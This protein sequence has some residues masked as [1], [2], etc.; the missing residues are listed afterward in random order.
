MARLSVKG[1]MTMKQIY[2]KGIVCDGVEWIHEGQNRDQWTT[3]V[4]M[5]LKFL[6]PFLE[7]STNCYFS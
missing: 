4:N 7:Q 2:H 6:S 5:V 1:R 3:V